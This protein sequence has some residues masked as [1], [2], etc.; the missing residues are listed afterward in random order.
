M[1]PEGR[2]WREE[3]DRCGTKC[4]EEK[5]YLELSQPKL[6]SI[7]NRSSFGSY[8]SVGLMNLMISSKDFK[9]KSILFDSSEEVE[10]FWC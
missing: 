10:V 2:F 4:H 1:G 5:D 6:H 3:K 7:S 9:L 8:F